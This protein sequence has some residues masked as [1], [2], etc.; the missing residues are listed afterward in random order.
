VDDGQNF[1]GT[2]LSKD[3]FLI[4]KIHEDAISFS[5]VVSQIVEN[6]HL[7]MFRKFPDLHSETNDFQHL[8]SSFLSTDTYLII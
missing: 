4:K 2:S 5:R 7:A 1:V 6:V 8:L 3:T